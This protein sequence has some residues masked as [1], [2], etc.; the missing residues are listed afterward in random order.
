MYKLE[1]ELRNMR[2]E[3]KQMLNQIKNEEQLSLIYLYV[4]N[5]LKRTSGK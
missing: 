2:E 1:K 5:I 3:I 4:K